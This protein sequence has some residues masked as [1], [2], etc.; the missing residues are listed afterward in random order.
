MRSALG[1]V[2]DLN[3]VKRQRWSWRHGSIAGR[4]RHLQSIEGLPSNGLPI[5]RVVRRINFVSTAVILA[6][7]VVG[8]MEM[9]GTD[10]EK[11]AQTAPVKVD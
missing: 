8:G 2:A 4:Q 5:D 1:A 9:L 6:A 7:I 3:G 11:A 10:S